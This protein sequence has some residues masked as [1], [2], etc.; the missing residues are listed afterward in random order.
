M[1]LLSKYVKS[2]YNLMI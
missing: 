1:H 2:L